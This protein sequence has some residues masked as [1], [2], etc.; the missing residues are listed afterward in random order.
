LLLAKSLAAADRI[1]EDITNGIKLYIGYT[2]IVFLMVLQFT[3]SGLLTLKN[4][5]SW[6]T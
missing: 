3:L 4:Q 1:Y 5:L 2:S 6:L